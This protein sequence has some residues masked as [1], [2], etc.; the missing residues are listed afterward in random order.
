MKPQIKPPGGW[1]FGNFGAIVYASFQENYYLG[2]SF[3]DERV[4]ALRVVN[5]SAMVEGCKFR[6][7][8]IV[9]T[10]RSKKDSHNMS[11]DFL[12]NTPKTRRPSVP[13]RGSIKVQLEKSFWRRTPSLRER[14]RTLFV[15]GRSE[16]S[17]RR[18]VLI[19][20]D[21]HL[22][23]VKLQVLCFPWAKGNS[24]LNVIFE[25]C[26]DEIP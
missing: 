13:F 26:R 15:Q 18:Y 7:I 25:T 16:L 19:Y 22:W 8:I 17:G 1:K 12:E 9:L 4:E 24:F 20:Q 21:D 11:L 14:M 3:N 5:V 10:Q 23:R 2:V 6:S